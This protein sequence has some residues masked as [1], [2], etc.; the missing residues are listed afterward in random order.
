MMQSNTVSAHI[1][2][3]FDAEIKSRDIKR[4]NIEEKNLMRERM[5]TAKSILLEQ[6]CSRSIT[7]AYIDHE[8]G[9]RNYIRVTH[10]PVGMRSFGSEDV[11]NWIRAYRD[12]GA[13]QSLQSFLEEK[14]RP[15]GTKPSLVLSDH[16]ERGAEVGVIPV[17]LT[18]LA[19][20]FL[21]CRSRLNSMS[22]DERER[23][24]PLE[25]IKKANAPVIV[26]FILHKDPVHRVQRITIP[27]DGGK[28]MQTYFL[29]CD[30][31]VKTMP[32]THKRLMSLLSP[33]IPQMQ[34]M[35]ALKEKPSIPDKMC[36][37][38]DSAF[39]SHRER[40]TTRKFTISLMLGPP[41]RSV[42]TS[43]Q[44]AS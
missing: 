30:E 26:D 17:D 8:D 24:A 36:C 4:E 18:Y 1:E 40:F 28:L 9:K 29:K 6:L 20:D 32:V 38:I 10:V 44:N 13:G 21:H 37:A 7:C 25:D 39:V 34:D 19:T 23:L 14:M 35:H 43:H 41:I 3:Y 31:C 15:I 5:K 33:L 2:T 22:K 16:G 27:L 42:S 11:V 12:D